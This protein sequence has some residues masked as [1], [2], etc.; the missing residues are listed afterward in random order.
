M[1]TPDRRYVRVVAR[2]KFLRRMYP[3]TGISA[4]NISL[5]NVLRFAPDI[6][7]YS[8]ERLRSILLGFLSDTNFD[9][10]I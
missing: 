8:V 10:A 5:Y 7:L 2:W 6:P 4:Y 9:Y 3:A 1:P